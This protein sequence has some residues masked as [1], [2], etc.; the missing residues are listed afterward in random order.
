MNP[1]DVSLQQFFDA[2]RDLLSYVRT[3]GEINAD[4]KQIVRLERVYW[5]ARKLIIKEGIPLTT[6]G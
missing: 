2:T 5:R 1:H 6:E 4:D 3:H